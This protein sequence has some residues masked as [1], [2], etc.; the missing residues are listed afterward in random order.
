MR[1]R[2]SPS[3][4]TARYIQQRLEAAG[5]RPDSRRGQNFLVD[6]N[7]VDL[8]VR[9]ANLQP[10]DVILEVGTGT[11]SLTS[12]MVSLVSAVVTV[13]VD[14]MLFQM[15]S[16]ELSHF[17]NVTMLR[18]D[19]LRN[20][21]NIHDGVMEAV[22][23]QMDTKP[24]RQFKLVANLPYH[25]AT[26]LISNL[27]LSPIVPSSMTVTIQ[28]ELADRIVAVPS[29]KDYGALS[30]W[31]QSL[32]DAHIVRVLPPQVFWPRPKVHSAIMKIEPCPKKR[33]QFADLAYYQRFVRSLF[34]HRR[35][36]MRSVLQ[37]AFKKQLSKAAVDD[38][39]RQEDFAG[40]RRAEELDKTDIAR[41]AEAF[42]TRLHEQVAG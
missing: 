3:R 42:R 27:L 28:K 29:T 24:Q 34:L 4:H 21:N 36:Y 26:P 30:V 31:I 37:S 8:L 20:K 38:V 33:S 16:D 10:H 2:T 1:E 15:A 23:S 22:R 40:E 25:I 7:L 11:G 35:K 5:I 14:P 41:L 18:Q 6:L 17:G 32:C 12:R 13:E 19:V 39:L 9:E